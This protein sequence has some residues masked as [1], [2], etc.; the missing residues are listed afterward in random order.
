MAARGRPSKYTPEI[1][2]EIC[3]RLAEGETLR[4]VCR[5]EGIPTEG[6]VRGW[7]LSDYHGFSSQYATAREI[8]YMTMADELLEIADDGTNDWSARQ[9]AD[10]DA[11]E[12]AL[13]GE[14]IQR[15][16][17]RVDTRKWLLSKALPKVYGDRQEIKHDV[18]DPMKELLG[19]VSENGKRVGDK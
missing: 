3:D 2:K 8:G 6:A 19:Y 17:L 15:S 14:H 7:V 4:Q 1:A 18:S 16:R 12:V 9:G 13:N 5:S 11:G 10:G